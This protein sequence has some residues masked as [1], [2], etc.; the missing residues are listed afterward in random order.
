MTGQRKPLFIRALAAG[1]KLR[2]DAS[3]SVSMRHGV[4][5]RGH[6]SAN[7]SHM[8]TFLVLNVE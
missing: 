8:V 1:A 3:P 4:E 7:S 5:V 2:F 6:T